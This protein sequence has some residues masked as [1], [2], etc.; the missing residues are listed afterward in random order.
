VARD[1]DTIER[2]I[3]KARTALAASLDELT[4]R[5]SPQRLS[6]Q[7]KEIAARKWADPKIKYAVIA[8][9]SVLGLLILRKIV[10]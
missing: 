2:E 10:K 7:G 4:E 9:G 8:A 5:A 1:P 6:E 3:E